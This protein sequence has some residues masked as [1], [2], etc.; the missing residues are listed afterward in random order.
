MSSHLKMCPKSVFGDNPWHSTEL[1]QLEFHFS[2]GECVCVR[3]REPEKC[4]TIKERALSKGSF[5]A[6]SQRW[7]QLHGL[8][9]RRG[10]FLLLMNSSFRGI[11]WGSLCWTHCGEYAAVPSVE[12]VHQNMGH[13]SSKVF[14]SGK[15]TL[16]QWLTDGIAVQRYLQLQ[17]VVN[18][19]DHL[20]LFGFTQKPGTS[21]D[22]TCLSF[23]P[24]PS[25]FF[26]LLVKKT[27]LIPQ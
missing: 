17:G 9:D 11:W 25:P 10:S 5:K 23:L 6:S 24:L 12:L 14:E 15:S 27:L 19:L 21:W 26:T 8:F 13:V 3:E 18:R 7:N 4:L 16:N 1:F 2:E 22:H 20:V